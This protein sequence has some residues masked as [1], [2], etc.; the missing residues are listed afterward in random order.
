MLTCLGVNCTDN[1]NFFVM[2]QKIKWT[3]RQKK[4]KKNWGNNSANYF[5][6]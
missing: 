3:G 4:K 1:D 6:F 2:H 5:L